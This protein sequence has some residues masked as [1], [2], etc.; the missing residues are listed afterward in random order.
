MNKA[1]ELGFLNFIISDSV[2]NLKRVET[3]NWYKT[4]FNNCK[5]VWIGPGINE[6]FTVKIANRLRN[7]ITDDFALVIYKGKYSIIKYI[8]ECKIEQNTSE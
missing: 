7:D 3:S 6:Q 1:R 4:G 2:S 5:T 8:S